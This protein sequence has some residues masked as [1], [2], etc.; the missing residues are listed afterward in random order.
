M[1][2]VEVKTL[3]N[4]DN[5]G[6]VSDYR[7]RFNIVAEYSIHPIEQYPTIKQA[8]AFLRGYKN[9]PIA[10]M[11]SEYRHGQIMKDCLLVDGMEHKKF[12]D[13]DS[14]YPCMIKL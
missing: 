3:A 9:L 5:V 8:I 10:E 12:I 13:I 2:L 6:I 4:I 14:K 1:L 11:C 7:G